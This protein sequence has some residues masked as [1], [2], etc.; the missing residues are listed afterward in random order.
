MQNKFT[1]QQKSHNVLVVKFDDVREGW[2][3][4]IMLSS[5]R[6]HDNEHCD[7]RLERQHLED[8]KSRGALI[9]AFGDTL[10][11]MQGFGDKRASKSAL[12]VEDKADDYLDSIVR[13]AARDYAP[14]APNWLLFSKGNHETSQIKQHG[15]CLTNALACKLN[16]QLADDGN[17]HR[18]A[19]GGYGGWIKFQFS[20]QGTQRQ[21]MNLKYFHGSGGNAQVTKGVIDTARQAAYLPDADIVVNGH[22]HQ[23]YHVVAT[24]ER[25]TP[26]GDIKLDNMDFV[27]TASYKNE[28]GDGSGGWSVEK[29][30]APTPLGCAWLRLYY[31]NRQV[32]RQIIL[33]HDNG[34]VH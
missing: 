7:R 22:N 3:Q 25:L 24:R 10:D 29:G 19:T 6:H 2:E 12:R 13:N 23:M 9:C 21:S 34:R 28:F 16:L 5:D 17:S 18:I 20:I 14:Y 4:W 8:A 27:R 33:D 30:F 32:R 11:A 26:Q 1:I 31:R 15:H